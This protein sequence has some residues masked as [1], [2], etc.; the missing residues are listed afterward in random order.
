MGWIRHGERDPEPKQ[1]MWLSGPAGAGKTAI[2]GSI[3]ESCKEEG[4]LAASFFF[5]SFSGSVDRRSKRCFVATLAHHIAGHDALYQFKAQLHDSIERHPDIFRKNL[6]EQ[7]EYLLIGP[8]RMIRDQCDTREW[9]KII[10]VDGLDEVEA[11]QYHDPTRQQIR[12]T[13]EDDQ[14]EILEILHILSQDPA[15][16]FRFFLA[17]R[18]EQGIAE[19]FATNGRAYTT[20]LFLDSKYRPDADIRRFLHSKFAGIRRRSGMSGDLW[21]GDDVVN[22]IVDMSSGQ[23]IVPATIIRYISAGVP[24]QQL[25]DVLQLGRVKIGT[26]NPFAVLD[27]L[28]RYILKRSHNPEDD[29]NL[30]VKWI[31][32]ITA[33]IRSQNALYDS[34]PP[35]AQFWRQFF[36]DMEGELGYRMAPIT[37]LV[38]V[39]PPHDTSSPITNYHKSLTDFLSSE[40][41][42]GDLFV[43][44][45]CLQHFL[46]SRIVRVLKSASSVALPKY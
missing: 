46:G 32:C 28:Y 11:M 41:R 17:S 40:S 21:P 36:E 20:D 19:F 7:A 23:F 16:P 5:S 18:P 35:S 15:F 13:N 43:S 22:R 24:Q 6:R 37:S 27:A 30:V 33:G 14:I 10:V 26:K 1:I 44:D 4:L 34:A 45:A 3:A 9:P 38:S 29:P 25:N 39:P 2:T 42:C 31:R 12:R 8:F